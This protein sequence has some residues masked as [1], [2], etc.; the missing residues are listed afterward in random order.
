MDRFKAKLSG[1][2]RL[3][4]WAG[5]R[6]STPPTRTIGRFFT[7]ASDWPKT[8]S[9]PTRKRWTA[10]SRG[11][12]TEPGHVRRQG[13]TR[14]LQLQKSCWR[15]GRSRGV[16]GLLLRAGCRIV[17]RYRVS[18]S[19]FFRYTGQRVRTGSEGHRP[20]AYQRLKCPMARLDTVR[21]ISHNFGYGI[22]DDMDSLRAEYEGAFPIVASSA[23][24]LVARWLP[25]LPPD[26]S[27]LPGFGAYRP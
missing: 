23:L 24:A 20:V 8:F 6:I 5:L 1:F 17:Q 11:C 18:G 12:I 22:G 26:R 13:Q 16:D 21:V 7:P 9:R 2:D 15:T 3:D 10:G 27:S 25:M 19:W 14:H 4:C